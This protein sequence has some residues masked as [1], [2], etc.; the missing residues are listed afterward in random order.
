MQ[1]TLRHDVRKAR[2]RTQIPIVEPAPR[3]PQRIEAVRQQQAQRPSKNL[4]T[5][6]TLGS[7]QECAMLL[8]ARSWQ[9]QLPCF[10]QRWA[11]CWSCG[12]RPLS[13]GALREQ[14]SSDGSPP[15]KP[16]SP[17]NRAPYPK[18]ASDPF[19]VAHKYVPLS[20]QAKGFKGASDFT[21]Y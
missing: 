5:P 9:G 13:A 19:N 17:N 4:G 10:Q 15:L 1:Q 2:P 8:L 6:S 12:D 11:R 16:N 3:I 18:V 21:A 20:F 7:L 14:H